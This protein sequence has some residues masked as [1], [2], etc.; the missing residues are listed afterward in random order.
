MVHLLFISGGKT[1][2]PQL[3][4]QKNGTEYKLWVQ[5]WKEMNFSMAE[6]KAEASLGYDQM[7]LVW[8]CSLNFKCQVQKICSHVGTWR[9]LM[10]RWLRGLTQKKKNG[11]LVCSFLFVQTIQGLSIVL[12]VKVLSRW[13]QALTKLMVAHLGK[14]LWDLGEGRR[15]DS[16]WRKTW[17]K[18]IGWRIQPTA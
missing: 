5:R 4:N 16:G 13:K 7:T 9:V 6:K 17:G 18:F 2:E 15:G 1:N 11:D 12:S 3:K 8:L 10:A 14:K